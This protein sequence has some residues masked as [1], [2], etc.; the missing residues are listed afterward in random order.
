MKMLWNE[1]ENEI[2]AE[3]LPIWDTRAETREGKMEKLK[4]FVTKLIHLLP[5]VG[6]AEEQVIQIEVLVALSVEGILT[7]DNLEEKAPMVRA[8]C[9]MIRFDDEKKETALAVARRLLK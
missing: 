4:G 3:E 5:Y 6:L 8:V 9:E 1:M 2:P 7:L